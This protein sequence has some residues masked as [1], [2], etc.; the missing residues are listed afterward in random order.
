MWQT[1]T[2][3]NR[4][5]NVQFIWNENGVEL[6]GNVPARLSQAEAAELLGI[7]RA[8]MCALRRAKILEPMGTKAS[9]KRRTNPYNTATYFT[10]EIVKIMNNEEQMDLVQWA[11]SNYNDETGSNK[12][13]HG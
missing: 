2:N 6:R 9:R 1:K 4:L 8:D 7:R 11:I 13:K 5:L 3:P 10:L 12:V